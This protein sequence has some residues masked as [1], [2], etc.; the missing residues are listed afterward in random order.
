MTT[1]KGKIGV[2]KLPNAVTPSLQQLFTK[3]QLTTLHMWDKYGIE[4]QI[5]NKKSI[6]CKITHPQSWNLIQIEN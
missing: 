3:Y 1:K 2:Q 5:F 6:S 4:R